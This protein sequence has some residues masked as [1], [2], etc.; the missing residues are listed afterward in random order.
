[1]DIISQHAF[2]L[3]YRLLALVW[4]GLFI[5]MIS[6]CQ[7]QPKADDYFPLN[8]GL[9]WSYQVTTIS[10]QFRGVERLTIENQ[11]LETRSDLGSDLTTTPIAVRRTSDGTDY[12]LYRDNT[13]LYRAAKRTLIEKNPR[14][15]TSP[16]LVMPPLEEMRDGISWNVPTRP[17]LIHSTRSHV[18]WNRAMN[19]FDLTFELTSENERLELP[20]GTFEHC[21]KLEGRALIGLYADP[22]LGYQ[23]VEV[24][25]T[26]WYA[27]GVGLVKLVREEPLN[28]EMFTGGSKTIELVRFDK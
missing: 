6:G 15:D 9:S 5:W 20:G 24:V 12:Y 17:Y 16:I 3:V 13:G 2:K 8:P 22:K 26:E 1:M 4:V 23:E 19:P 21:L 7:Q 18:A 11:Q 10:G 28:L 27:P 14:L 25:Q